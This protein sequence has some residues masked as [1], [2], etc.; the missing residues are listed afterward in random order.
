MSGAR[1]AARR[2]QAVFSWLF[3]LAIGT[4]LAAPVVLPIT[5][6]ISDAPF[7][8]FPPKGFTLR[9]FSKIF[10]DDE[11]VASLELSASTPSRS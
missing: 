4:F 9:W 1:A 5:L 6:S 2:R 8:T 3:L 7:L 11:F 10:A